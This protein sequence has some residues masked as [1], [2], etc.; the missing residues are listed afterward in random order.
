M[1]SQTGDAPQLGFEQVAGN[2][3]VRGPVS[4]PIDQSVALEL[5][6]Q[7]GAEGSRVDVH[8]HARGHRL[9]LRS[10]SRIS[11]RLLVSV[12]RAI[13]NATQSPYHRA[14]RAIRNVGAGSSR[15]TI[16]PTGTL[17]LVRTKDHPSPT[18][19][20]TRLGS[21]RSSR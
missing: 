3:R 16:L 5:F 10:S 14:G 18:A 21:L 8:D 6:D 7:Q 15:G 9:S 13:P 4:T 19:R 1:P 17:L 12:L 20:K 2:Q 11:A